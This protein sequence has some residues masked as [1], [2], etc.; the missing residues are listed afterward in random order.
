[1]LEH[2]FQAPDGPLL[3]VDDAGGG[4]LPVVF[5]HGLCGDV[6]QTR[7]AFPA[8]PAFRRIT[9]EMRGHGA[10]EAGNPVAFSMAAFCDDLAAFIDTSGLA[11]VVVGGISMGAAI[12]VRLAVKRP[13]L[14]RGLILARPAWVTASSPDNMKPNAEAGALLARLP[15]AD[16]FDAFM[17]GTAASEL[18]K[19]APDSQAVTAA[20]LQRISADGPEVT[21]I[22][23][24]AVELPTLIIGHER[25]AI[26]PLAHAHALHR[27]IRHSSFV[28]ITPKTVDRARYIIDFHGAVRAF[29]K[30]L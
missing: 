5:Q 22:E 7:E 1:M 8:D 24:R 20:L 30:D 9:V 12:A 16:A 10:S 26:H 3:N 14:V 2:Q 15:Q 29:L 11:P 6:S 25:D 19:H 17:A 13:E 23:V 18:A 21:E 4:G 28:E 27:M